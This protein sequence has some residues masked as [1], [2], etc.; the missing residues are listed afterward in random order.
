VNVNAHAPPPSWSCAFTFAFTVHVGVVVVVLVVGK[1]AMLG[2]VSRAL[3]LATL[4]L[5]V[6]AA[7]AP[8]APAEGASLLGTR[9][10]ALR[11]LK[12]LQGGPLSLETLRGKVV[13]IRFWTDGCPYC[14]K[15][16]PALTSLDAKYRDKGLVVIGIHHP[17]EPSSD[18][19]KGIH[20]LG[21]KFPVAT[22][23]DWQ[24]VKAYGVGT[25]FT[26]FTSVSFLIDREGVIRFVHDGGEW[27][28]GGGADHERCNQ[29]FDALVAT[30]KR[31]L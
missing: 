6:P 22:D 8:W 5:A 16:A 28:E 10:P 19:V 14:E 15:T 2:D 17:K 26:H 29:A 23:P 24:T 12:W 9:A 11:G 4:L 25:T 31:L 7:A 30:L 27:H 18:P 3:L 20:A 1:G 21:L 13:L